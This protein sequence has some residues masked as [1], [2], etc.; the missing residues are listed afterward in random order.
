MVTQPPG[1]RRWSSIVFPFSGT[2]PC[3]VAGL[4]CATQVRVPLTRAT[5]G[6]A[7]Y[8]HV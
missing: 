1:V 5:R 8:R 4:T 2:W 6:I 7:A 3:G